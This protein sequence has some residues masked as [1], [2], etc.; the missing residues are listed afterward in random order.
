MPM[1]ASQVNA[2]A[3]LVNNQG[4]SI[5][6]E[7]TETIQK[8]RDLFLVRNFKDIVEHKTAVTESARALIVDELLPIYRISVRDE[9]TLSSAVTRVF[10]F[11]GH[12][13]QFSD[14]NPLPPISHS[15]KDIEELDVGAA[16]LT[17][18]YVG[19]NSV[20]TFGGN[21]KKFCTFFQTLSG[22]CKQLNEIKGI[23]HNHNSNAN[24]V[25]FKGHDSA[26]TGGISDVCTSTY[27]FGYDLENLGKALNLNKI[28]RFGEPIVLLENLVA[29]AGG[30]PTFVIDA[31]VNEG[32]DRKLVMQLGQGITPSAAVQN[33]IYIALT[34]IT[35][36]NLGYMLSMLRVKNTH[37][38][39]NAA[40]LLDLSKLF[41][42]A[43]YGLKFSSTHTIFQRPDRVYGWVSSLNANGL[44]AITTPVLA[45]SAIAFRNSLLQ[46]TGVIDLDTASLG[47]VA[48]E[49]DRVND[50][51]VVSSEARPINSPNPIY[52]YV[53]SGSGPLA[54]YAMRD[55]I[56]LVAGLPETMMSE[57]Q[58]VVAEQI[59]LTTKPN[60]STVEFRLS[61]VATGLTNPVTFTVEEGFNPETGEGVAPI[62]RGT[63]WS[64]HP[65]AIYISIWPNPGS[66]GWGSPVATGPEEPLESTEDEEPPEPVP[67]VYTFVLTTLSRTFTREVVSES[68]P[69]NE[70]EIREIKQSL[71][72]EAVSA[73]APGAIQSF[74]RFVDQNLQQFDKAD[75]HFFSFR[76]YFN[77]QFSKE[78]STRERYEQENQTV[79]AMTTESRIGLAA[80]AEGLHQLGKEYD[81]LAN[82]PVRLRA[83]NILERMCSNTLAGQSII[84]AMREG[85]NLEKLSRAGIVTDNVKSSKIK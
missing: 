71:R 14:Y 42:H 32:V 45:K 52:S 72:N 70:L 38:F 77:T 20:C 27:W 18:V 84:A 51:P 83:A 22:H 15:N 79:F 33:K 35:G 67:W 23:A 13:S 58:A 30:L 81:Q 53:G 56:G 24:R 47:K 64:S 9:N 39:T 21:Y 61:D 4:L 73:I 17:D 69:L 25:T 10:G 5:P 50:L 31:I 76:N 44:D 12:W 68:R 59:D 2:L 11:N 75:Q 8:Y 55:F 16:Y 26:V 62:N 37:G 3:G 54:L 63:A 57:F 29:A 46:I 34:R 7:V 40:E 66:P 78:V 43:F 36:Q 82:P 49:V 41:P 80:F 1:S 74:T 19:W 85:R 28:A 60:F 6:A 48:R 65:D